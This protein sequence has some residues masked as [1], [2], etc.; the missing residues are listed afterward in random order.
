[1]N[2]MATDLNT[3]NAIM[4]MT[5]V[6]HL[7]GEFIGRMFCG[8]II[9]T[10][11]S[12]A[13][14]L[15]S[16]AASMA[17]HL[18]CMI[19]GSAPIFMI[20]RFIQAIGS[21]V[22]YIVSQNIIDETFDDKEKS[23][24][25]GIIELYQPIAWILSP[26]IGSIL[27]EISNW[28]VSFLVLMLTQLVGI[29]FFYAYPKGNPKKMPLKFSKLLRNYG[30]VLQNS[31]FVIYAL[32][33]GMFAGGYMIFAAA[34]PF[35]CSSFFDNHSAIALFSVIPLFFYVIATFAYRRIVRNFGTKTSRKIGTGIYIAF[36]VYMMHLIIHHSPWTPTSLLSL[37]CLQCA[38]SAFL[39]PISV[40]KALQ[41]TTHHPKTVGASTVVIFRNLIMSICISAGAKFRG[42]VTT[43]MACVFITVASALMLIMARKIIRTRGNKR[44]E[45]ND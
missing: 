10:Y 5:I 25:M 31:M 19:S 36:G 42:D 28:R 29:A 33:P 40:L 34:A 21:S 9:E 38:G 43:I 30:C 35:I 4:H 17:G 2:Q 7:V 27:A 37:M 22:I 23:Y 16:L 45:A 41:Y 20:M 39:V 14:I 18:G 11:G 32:I 12:R 8:P 13:T 44:R 15:P 6:A 26:F 3:T 1:M 24:V